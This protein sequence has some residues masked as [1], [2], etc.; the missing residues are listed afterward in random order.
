MVWLL[1]PARMSQWITGN[2]AACL[3]VEDFF[4]IPALLSEFAIVITQWVFRI[5]VYGGFLRARHGKKVCGC[6]KRIMN[7]RI[8]PMIHQQEKSVVLAS[9]HERCF[10]DG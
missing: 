2:V 3:E 9:F 5:S 7:L 6:R 10:V 8:A 4:L 1:G